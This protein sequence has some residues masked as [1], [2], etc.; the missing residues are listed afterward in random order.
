MTYVVV[1]RPNCRWCI[2]ACRLLDSQKLDYEYFEAAPTGYGMPA[3]VVCALLEAMG[4]TTVPQ[5][6]HGAK[7][8][9]GYEALVDYLEAAA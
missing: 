7:H 2:M 3:A 4:L 1:G 9:G 6:W 8:V 5:V